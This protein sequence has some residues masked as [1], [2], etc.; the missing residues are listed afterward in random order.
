MLGWK[1]ETLHA[2]PR[3]ETLLD[4]APLWGAGI[5]GKRPSIE[6]GHHERLIPWEIDHRPN[7]KRADK[8]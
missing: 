3:L 4:D 7:A 1:P 5:Y 8:L 2:E 6:T